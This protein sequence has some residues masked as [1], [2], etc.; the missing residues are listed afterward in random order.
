MPNN[1]AYP[2]TQTATGVHL[3]IQPSKDEVGSAIEKRV[4]AWTF[5]PDGNLHWVICLMQI[6]GHSL[7]AAMFLVQKTLNQFRFCAMK[8]VK[9]MMPTLIIFMTKTT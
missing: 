9:S 4:A 6:D 8:S 7:T 1:F 2:I 5:L 3:Y